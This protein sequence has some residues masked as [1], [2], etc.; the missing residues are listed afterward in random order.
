MPHVIIE[1]SANV[2][3]DD[4][5]PIDIAA[6]VDVL[7]D[8]A[9]ATGIAPLDALRTRA[10]ARRYYAVADR[11][12]DNMFVAVTARLGAGRSDDD[13]RRLVE[14]L[15]ASL[16]GFLGDVQRSMMLS[17]EYQEIDPTFRIN[18][19]NVRPLV[20]ERRGARTGEETR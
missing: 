15:M 20:A 5:G 1:Y 14:A 3:T 4:G 9:L 11:H 19:N 2:A 10:A 13:K 7:H 16:D 12:P 18:K 17:V 6:L 8:A